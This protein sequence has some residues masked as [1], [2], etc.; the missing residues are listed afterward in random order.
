MG[1]PDIVH[2]WGV[3][4]GD[5][6]VGF[7]KNYVYDDAWVSMN[8]TKIV[9]AALRERALYSLMYRMSE[10]YLGE[11]GLRCMSDGTRSMLHGAEF[12]DV[13]RHDFGFVNLPLRMERAYRHPLAVTA[14]MLL[15][16]S[17]VD[18]SAK[19]RGLARFERIYRSQAAPGG[20][21][22]AD[23]AAVAGGGI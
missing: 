15:P 8:T 14:V 18:R 1:Y 20:A 13:L 2:Y 9:Q 3:W 7:S 17:V 6:L 19:L 22:P 21:V 16:P 10:H 12:Q 11:R 23:R 4:R 5:E